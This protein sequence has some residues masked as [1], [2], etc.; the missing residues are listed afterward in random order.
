MKLIKLINEFINLGLLDESFRQKSEPIT[1]YK[2]IKRAN[3]DEMRDIL[4]ELVSLPEKAINLK[5]IEK[6]LKEEK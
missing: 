6:W 2:R 1:N 3:I 5:V 4:M